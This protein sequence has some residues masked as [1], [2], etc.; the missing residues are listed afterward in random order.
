MAEEAVL[1]LSADIDRDYSEMDSMRQVLSSAL[2]N[3]GI[4]DS[5][6]SRIELSVYEAIINIIEYSSPQY[7][8]DK[9]MIE[10]YRLRNSI[11]IV[12]RSSGEK[13]DLRK[14]RLPDIEKHFNEGKKRGL[15]IYFI[16]TLMDKI[17]YSH[18]NNCN[19]LTM[20]KSINDI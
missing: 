17:D 12:I 8:N 6:V 15:G 19:T 5:I 10:Y 2:K 3:N 9:I 13:F 11:K 14:A 4:S 16:R 1:F 18:K 7:K 20:I